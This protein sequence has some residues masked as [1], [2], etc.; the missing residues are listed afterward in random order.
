MKRQGRARLG[1][2]G[3]RSAQCEEGREKER[4]EGGGLG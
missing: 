1:R 3:S 4:R 2:K